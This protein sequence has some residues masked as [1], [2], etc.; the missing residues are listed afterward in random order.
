MNGFATG[1]ISGDGGAPYRVAIAGGSGYGGAELLRWLASHPRFEAVGV[2]SR[3]HEGKG[4][5]DV[6]PNLA[7]FHADLRFVERP[8]DL[9]EEEPDAVF[10]ALPHRHAAEHAAQIAEEQ[11]E[12]VIVDLSGDHRLSD[13]AT[14]ESAYAAQH[15]YPESLTDGSWVF[16]L[17]EANRGALTGATRIAN[18]GCFATGALLA[19][20]PLAQAGWIDGPVRHSA[21]TG[22]S[23]GG[24]SPKQGTHHPERVE[25]V[26]A[27]KVLR[28]QHVPEIVECLSGHGLDAEVPWLMVPQ[29]GPFAR[30]IFTTLFIDLPRDVTTADLVALYEKA[31]ADSP[32]V[33]LRDA[34]PR[35]GQ[36]TGTNFCDI[37]VHADG[38][39]AVVLSAI[40]NLGK[41]MASQAIQNLNLAFGLPETTGLWVPGARP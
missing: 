31:Y 3:T 1:G 14:Y 7:G 5:S 4:V 10:L 16:G 20:L 17:T 32:F 24:I 33:R 28:H 9:L 22:S 25:D 40:D 8:L 30:G 41:G 11:P 15:P 39:A 23:G 12:I 35:I 26:K 37:A 27:Y 18:P 21:I 36:V 2:S 34:T 6:H 13:P 29:S 38:S 19:A